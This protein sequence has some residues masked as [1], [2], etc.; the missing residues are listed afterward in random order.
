MS[1]S[2]ELDYT[3]LRRRQIE[4]T[5][6]RTK[7]A[8]LLA[9]GYPKTYTAE[10]VGVTR[11]TIYNWLDDPEFHMEVDR[12]TLMIDAASRA[13]R[14]R[15][16]YRVLRAK[17]QEDGAL[18]TDKDSLDWLKYAQSETD[19]VKLDLSK[20]TEL[21]DS[22]SQPSSPAIDTHNNPLSL[23]AEPLG[24]VIEAVAE[25][26]QPEQPATTDSNP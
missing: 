8:Y 3:R 7:A 2:I 1:T 16:V 12:L 19:G 21:D 11:A 15:E 18:R 14:M 20:L 26:G 5:T 10:Q 9:K 17:R 23:S 6:V 13:E 22:G 24:Q 25:P 4:W